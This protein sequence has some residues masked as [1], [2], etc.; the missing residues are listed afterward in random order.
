MTLTGIVSKIVT[1]ITLIVIWIEFQSIRHRIWKAAILTP[2]FFI[3]F[4]LL[5]FLV[6]LFF[7]GSM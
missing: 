6:A 4:L 1:V 7:V 5:L 3:I 2:I